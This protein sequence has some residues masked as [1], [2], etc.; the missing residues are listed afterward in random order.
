MIGA[1]TEASVCCPRLALDSPD[2]G[3]RRRCDEYHGLIADLSKKARNLQAIIEPVSY[4]AFSNRRT[5]QEL[6]QC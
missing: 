3:I 1:H 2:W 5:A 6:L 4:K